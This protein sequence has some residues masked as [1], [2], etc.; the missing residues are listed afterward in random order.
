MKFSDLGLSDELSQ[1]VAELGYE[2]PTP[3]QEKSIPVVLMGRDILGSAQTGTGKTASFTLPMIDILASGRAKARLPRSLILAPTRELAAQVAE[4]FEKFSTHHKLSMALL[5]GGVSFADQ[6]AALVKGVD[7]LIATPG[8]LI[9]H[10]ERGKVMLNDVKVLVIDEADRMLDMGFIPDVERIVGLLPPLRQTLF[11]SATLSDDIH[12]ISNKFV[13]NPKI[14]EVAPP[15]STAETVAQHIQWTDVKN[16]RV[17]LRDLLRSETVKNAVIFCNRKR[18]ISTLIKSLTN[19]GF[20]AVA[21]HGD[22][23]QS[24]RLEALDKFKKGEVPL[25]IAS[26]VAA[27]GLDIAGLSHVFNFDVPTS[28]ED[29]VHR[30]G[31][32]GRAGKSGR[33]FTIAAG[34]DDKRYVG[35]IESLIG[36]T[37]PLIGD[38]GGVQSDTKTPDTKTSAAKDADKKPATRGK[39]PAAKDAKPDAAQADKKPASSAKPKSQNTKEPRQKPR[40]GNTKDELPS[41]PDCQGDTLEATGHV[42]AFLQ[43]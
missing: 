10:F 26:D 24:A 35:A 7:V 8:R 37:I 33:A 36:K 43:R 28:A 11:F 27:R 14:I 34:K 2:S 20:S 9:D 32:T 30:I 42:P 6:N 41:P 1:A 13:S 15:A 23:T 25:L 29:Y 39:K 22:M 38:A 21:M 40:N 3:I 5:I 31:R 17:V 19:H 4:S 18:D 12:K 16:K